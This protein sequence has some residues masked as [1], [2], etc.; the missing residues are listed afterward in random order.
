MPEL[1]TATHKDTGETLTRHG[2]PLVA[3]RKGWDGVGSVSGFLVGA[4]VPFTG[5]PTCP[6]YDGYAS[7]LYEPMT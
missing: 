5:E 2:V 7:P 6:L 1:F 3:T 4:L